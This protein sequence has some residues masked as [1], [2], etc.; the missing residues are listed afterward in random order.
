MQQFRFDLKTFLGL[1]MPNQ[2]SQTVRKQ[3]SIWF[4]RNNFGSKPPNLHIDPYII[5]I[6]LLYYMIM[7]SLYHDMTSLCLN[8]TQV[9]VI[10]MLLKM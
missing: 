8:I 9:K 7:K 2:Y 1:A 10:V 5:Y 6:L 4:W 3:I